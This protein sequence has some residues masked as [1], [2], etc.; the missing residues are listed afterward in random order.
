ML[1]EMARGYSMMTML[2]KAIE[3]GISKESFINI[4][5]KEQATPFKNEE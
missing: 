2:Y 5:C 1:D 4:Y 3:K